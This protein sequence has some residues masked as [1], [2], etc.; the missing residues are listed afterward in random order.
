[1]H[2]VVMSGLVVYY[3]AQVSALTAMTS[4]LPK[5][6]DPLRQTYSDDTFKLVVKIRFLSQDVD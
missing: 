2:Y 5:L 6:W 3:F 4:R 1:M